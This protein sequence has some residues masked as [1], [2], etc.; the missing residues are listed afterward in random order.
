MA[1]FHLRIHRWIEARR[2][3]KRVLWLSDTVANSPSVVP[4]LL[5]AMVSVLVLF[6]YLHNATRFYSLARLHASACGAVLCGFVSCTTNLPTLIV[7]FGTMSHLVKINR[8]SGLVST[9][10]SNSSPRGRL[11][12]VIVLQPVV[13]DEATL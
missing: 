10:P 5:R 9:S 11:F 12:S 4:R 7:S 6:L 3:G 8:A 13:A 2:S 1:C